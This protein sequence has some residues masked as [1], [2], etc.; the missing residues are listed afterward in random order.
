VATSC[1]ILAIN[2]VRIAVIVAI[3]PYHPIKCPLQNRMELGSAVLTAITYLCNLVAY[4]VD[5]PSSD[6]AVWLFGVLMCIYAV[7]YAAAEALACL[8]ND[9]RQR[10]LDNYI[11][12]KPTDEEWRRALMMLATNTWSGLFQEW[13]PRVEESRAV[14]SD[15]LNKQAVQEKW[16]RD[17]QE[18]WSEQNQWTCRAGDCVWSAV[19][20]ER[21]LN[22]TQAE[23]E[24]LQ[25][26]KKEKESVANHSLSDTTRLEAIE[27]ELAII[28]G[29][30]PNVI[31]WADMP[32]CDTALMY[33]AS[34]GHHNCAKALLDWGADTTKQG[35]DGKTA[36]DIAREPAES[37][38]EEQKQGK[39]QIVALLDTAEDIEDTASV[40]APDD[41]PIDD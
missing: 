2:V 19:E 38:G 5:D 1:F 22:A 9:E 31:K 30:D 34:S 8:R 28:A 29:R 18:E 32:I 17:S 33:A 26:E 12:A 15:K 20:V 3:E 4:A 23:K 16:R 24:K 13:T 10:T 7:G 40:G 27:V 41:P 21:L 25:A 36:L 11:V 35:K 39:A 14:W 37:D 6:A